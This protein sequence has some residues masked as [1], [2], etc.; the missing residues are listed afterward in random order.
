MKPSPFN[1]GVVRTCPEVVDSK[2]T[3]LACGLGR[4]VTLNDDLSNWLAGRPDWQKDAVARFCRNETLSVEDVA[5]I[6]DHLIAGT[7][8]RASNINVAD[9]PGSTSAGD[10][11][12]RRFV[13]GALKFGE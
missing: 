1:A 4:V 13:N 12:K 11:V 3:F 7:Y 5:A 9:I 8:P 6:G 10:P 2:R